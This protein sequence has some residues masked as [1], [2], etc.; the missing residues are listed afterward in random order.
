M[1]V[2]AILVGLRIALDKT[3][4]RICDAARDEKIPLLPMNTK[5]P[6]RGAEG[7]KRWTLEDDLVGRTLDFLIWGVCFAWLGVVG[8]AYAGAG[9]GWN[10]R[11]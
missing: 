8:I 5:S 7:V 6:P 10:G 3:N 4:A 1:L 2:S 9:L 11:V